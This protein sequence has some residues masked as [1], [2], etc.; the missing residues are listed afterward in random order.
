MKKFFNIL[1]E[2]EIFKGILSEELKD[3]MQCLN[4]KIIS[5]E[6]DSIVLSE[7]EPANSIGIVISGKIYVIKEDYYGNRSIMAKCSQGEIFG[8][9][10]CCSGI[11]SIPVS[12]FTAEKSEIMFLNF[13]NILTPCDKHCKF[14][15]RII[16]NLL[17]I[18]S[19]KAL[20]LN[21]KIDILSKRTTREKLLAYLSAQAKQ[22]NSSMFT[23]PFNRQELADFLCV[24]RSAMSAELSRMQR[25][26]II[27]FK[28]SQFKL[29]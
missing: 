12:V 29:L 16:P 11:N 27:E 7:G 22:A 3:I 2:T 18:V 28:K 19:E 13:K 1:T 9:V 17:N 10:F 24:E 26:R 6:K 20:F 23:I 14:H 5:Y 4:A 8:E 25:D 21:Q 15:N